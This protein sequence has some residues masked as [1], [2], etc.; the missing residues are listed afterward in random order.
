MPHDAGIG[1]FRLVHRILPEEQHPV[2]RA[3]ESN[4]RIVDITQLGDEE[5]SAGRN[6]E[7]SEL[8]RA[9]EDKVREGDEAFDAEDWATAKSAYEAAQDMKPMERYPK[10]RLRRIAS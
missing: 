3:E 2:D 6:D 4:A 7:A 10:N 8:D 1:L 9:Y 5:E